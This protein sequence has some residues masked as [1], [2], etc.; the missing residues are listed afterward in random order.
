MSCSSSSS[1]HNNPDADAVPSQ[2]RSIRSAPDP[3][4]PTMH[5]ISTASSPREEQSF[6]R[7]HTSNTSLSLSIV[8][9]NSFFNKK[10]Q[11]NPPITTTTIRI[12]AYKHL[13]YSDVP[14]AKSCCLLFCRNCWVLVLVATAVPLWAP[15]PAPSRPLSTMKSCRYHR[16]CCCYF[17]DV[18]LDYYSDY[19][20]GAAAPTA[21]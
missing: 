9:T 10:G 14:L 2:Y 13:Y 19:C 15:P 17:L 3:G 11:T 8:V 18:V 1:P 7:I 4:E 6:S 20:Y 5:E 16:H 21:D 12:Q